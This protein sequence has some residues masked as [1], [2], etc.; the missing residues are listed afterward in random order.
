MLSI[1]VE[2]LEA[3]RTLGD[4]PA[5]AAAL[6]VQTEMVLHP[7]I[8]QMVI[9]PLGAM[10]MLE[11]VAQEVLQPVLSVAMELSTQRHRNMA[12]AVVVAELPQIAYQ[13]L[14][15]MVEITAQAAV[16]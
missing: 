8:Q 1:Q 6:L 9:L 5:A 2:H 10:V 11:A 14:A 13:F 4:L 7:A 16:A 12:Q 15:A 3:Q